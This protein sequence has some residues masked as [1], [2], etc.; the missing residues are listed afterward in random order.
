MSWPSTSS[1]E[2]APT[3]KL[4]EARAYIVYILSMSTNGEKGRVVK[5]LKGRYS[6]NAEVRQWISH[7]R[8]L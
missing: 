2:L 7:E 1:V 6:W 5:G 4:P 3:G 8:G